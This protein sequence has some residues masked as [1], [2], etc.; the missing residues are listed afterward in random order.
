MTERRYAT[1][2]ANMTAKPAALSRDAVQRSRPATC[3]DRSM[4][5]PVTWHARSQARG[6]AAPRGD[7][8]RRLK[9]CSL[10]SNAFSGSIGSDQEGP[11]VRA[12]S[13]FSQQPPKT[14]ESWPSSYRCR[15]L[16]QPEALSG[17]QSA[18]GKLPASSSSNYWPTSSTK[19]TLNR[20]RR[21]SFQAAYEFAI[22]PT[23]GE[24]CHGCGRRVGS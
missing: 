17:S 15:A 13:S 5:A 1:A 16:T 9:C 7:C 11:T 10:I 19:S 18:P 4:K 23:D 20:H 14:S 2:V 24:H 12:M 6:K 21:A 22:F 3:R 8:A